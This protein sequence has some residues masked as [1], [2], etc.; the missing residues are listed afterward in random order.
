MTETEKNILIVEDNEFNSLYLS[1]VLSAYN[2]NLLNASNGHEAVKIVKKTPI[3]LIFMDVRMPEMDGREAAKKIRQ[4]YPSI[5]IV[6]QTAYT[7]DNESEQDEKIFDEYLLKP[8]SKEK[9]RRV[10]EEYL[11][12]LPQ[13]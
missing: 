13:K 6:A 11:H 1:E 8:I 12:I 3:D 9:I 10:V 2:V 4:D 7:S 5:A